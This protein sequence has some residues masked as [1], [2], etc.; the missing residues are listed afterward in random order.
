M[1]YLCFS[2]VCLQ[3]FYLDVAYV[4]ASVTDVCS[5]FLAVFVRIL[6][7]FHLDV[8]KVDLMLQQVYACF[9][10]FICL[11]TYVASVASGGF[12]SR[13]DVASSFSLFCC[14]ASVSLPPPASARHLS[15][16]PF[17][18]MLV[19]LGPTRALCGCSKWHGK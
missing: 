13:L 5:K 10:C 3:V 6:Q 11:H 12:K 14:L 1:F 8:S 16:L 18:S 17:F 4:F 7:V 15:P 19:T 2:Y 9:E